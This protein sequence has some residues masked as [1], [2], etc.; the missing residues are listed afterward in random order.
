MGP[1]LKVLGDVRGFAYGYFGHGYDQVA[2]AKVLL[3]I[4]VPEV[5]AYRKEL[6]KRCE[7]ISVVKYSGHL[8][9]D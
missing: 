4:G 9:D 2:A 3:E 5:Q 1:L 6:L 7:A 8:N